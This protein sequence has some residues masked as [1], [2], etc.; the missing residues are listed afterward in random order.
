LYDYEVVDKSVS[1]RFSEHSDDGY[2]REFR[3]V[4]R[5]GDGNKDILVPK[6]QVEDDFELV[7]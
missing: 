7:E 1:I 5:F 2:V 6:V 3:Y 4:L